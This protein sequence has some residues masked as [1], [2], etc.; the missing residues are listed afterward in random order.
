MAYIMELNTSGTY[1]S[2]RMARIILTKVLQKKDPG[3]VNMMNPCGF[4]RAVMTYAPD[5][6][7]YPTDEA[8]MLGDNIF[9]LGNIMYESYVK[10][11]NNEN[12]LF[13]LSA[14]CSDLWNYRSAYSPWLG[15]DPVVNYALEKNI[16]LKGNSRLEQVL[17]HQFRTVFSYLLGDKKYADVFH[18]KEGGKWSSI[19]KE[20]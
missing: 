8:R 13:L 12:L 1:M 17:I 9:R 14:G 20:R 19:S 5:G 15:V 16:V 10:M 2:E 18:L 3:Y 11:L 4:G 7:C 6:G